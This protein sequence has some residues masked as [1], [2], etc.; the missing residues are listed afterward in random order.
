MKHIKHVPSHYPTTCTTKLKENLYR[1]KEYM[2][3]KGLKINIRIR[4]VVVSG[5]N[6]NDVE[7]QG[8]V[9]SMGRC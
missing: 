6:Y 9:L 1:Y 3:A 2:E 5:K 8:R 4:K 7:R